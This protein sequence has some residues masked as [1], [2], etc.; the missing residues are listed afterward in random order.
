[1]RQEIKATK[2]ISATCGPQ[3]GLRRC[4]ESHKRD[5]SQCLPDRHMGSAH[6][7]PGSCHGADLIGPRSC[8]PVQSVAET[9]LHPLP[10]ALETAV[11][12]VGTV[13][14][15]RFLNEQRALDTG[16]LAI[17]CL[18]VGAALLPTWLRK[19]DFPPIGLGGQGML[20]SLGLVFLTSLCL[21]PMAFMGLWLAARLHLPLPPG[22]GPAVATPKDWVIWLIHQFM[23]VAVAEEVFFR[24][25]LQSNVTRLIAVA[26]PT[27]RRFDQYAA[28]I[29][30]A[31]CFAAA[32]VVV[33]GQIIALAT[34][35][36]GLVLAWLFI[37][38]RTL[39][40][41]ILFHGLANVSYGLFALIW[42]YQV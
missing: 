10:L 19:G 30:S 42:L 2:R 27:P 1:V 36:P 4:P 25:Y 18:L 38:T 21:I 13:T 12:V 28:A 8:T 41:P 37:R 33:Q 17:P 23:Y 20:R 22:P 9:R 26:H 39:L 3:A 24:G 32:H 7:A 14:A 11:V 31:G 35:L 40:A 5:N 34:F 29:I 16:W 15:V 6:P